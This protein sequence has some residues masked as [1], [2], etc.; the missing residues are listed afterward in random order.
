[1]NPQ[2]SNSVQQAGEV[3]RNGGLVGLPTE[4]VYGLAAYAR[5]LA[6]VAQLSGNATPCSTAITGLI[7]SRLI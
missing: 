5:N 7:R 4:T 3:L 6:G 1:M 2:S